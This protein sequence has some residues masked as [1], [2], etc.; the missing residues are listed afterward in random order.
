[1]ELFLQA[2]SSNS[3][4]KPAL[5]E[6]P[7]VAPFVEKTIKPFRTRSNTKYG[8]DMPIDLSGFRNFFT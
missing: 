5:N 7:E 4:L 6:S 8:G 2:V 3:Q 1:M